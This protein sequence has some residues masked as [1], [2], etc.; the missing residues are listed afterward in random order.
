MTISKSCVVA[1]VLLTL[2]SLMAQ[3]YPAYSLQVRMN[4]YDEKGVLVEAGKPTTEYH[5]KDGS[6]VKIGKFALGV[7][8]QIYRPLD[9]RSFSEF[10]VN[11][12]DKVQRY[13]KIGQVL[14]SRPPEAT[15]GCENF[16]SRESRTVTRSETMLGVPALVV[17]GGDLE[18]KDTFWLAPS[19]GCVPLKFV[20]EW[21]TAGKLNGAYT[22]ME[23]SDLVMGE[24]APAL[25]KLPDGPDVMPSEIWLTIFAKP[26]PARMENLNA[27]WQK[28]HQP[29]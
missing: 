21:K 25:L 26:S 15:P 4:V 6:Q 22:A 7:L 28:A 12:T 20:S 1:F 24:P 18:V 5:F 29:Q 2:G 9:A 23:A 27:R 3:E 16:F 17:E 19:L 13:S 10:I 14:N 8:K 11:D